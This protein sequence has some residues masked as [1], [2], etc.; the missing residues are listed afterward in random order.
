MR[1]WGRCDEK[2]LERNI[3][4]EAPDVPLGSVL[5]RGT[6]GHPFMEFVVNPHCSTGGHWR[7]RGTLRIKGPA[8]GHI[9]RKRQK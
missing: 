7:L 9:T 1:G 6:I 5:S 8:H 4:P 2:T 3:S